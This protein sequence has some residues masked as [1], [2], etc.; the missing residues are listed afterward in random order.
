MQDHVQESDRCVVGG[1]QNSIQSM[2]DLL[3]C[4][5]GIFISN[6]KDFWKLSLLSF[7]SVTLAAVLYCFHI[8]R[9]RK[10]LFH[11]EKLLAVIPWSIRQS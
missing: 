9:V 10:Y 2:M 1:V 5:R 11:F 3:T 4:I 7:S 8:Y 6:P